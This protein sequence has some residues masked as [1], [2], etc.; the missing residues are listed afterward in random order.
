MFVNNSRV[1]NYF[2]QTTLSRH[3]KCLLHTGRNPQR[4]S[5]DIIQW[6]NSEKFKM[7]KIFLIKNRLH[8]QQQRLLESQ[9]RLEGVVGNNGED[10]T[11]ALTPPESPLS[12]SGNVPNAP[13]VPDVPNAPCQ[14]L[15]LIVQ[16]P[17]NSAGMSLPVHLHSLR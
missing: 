17:G 11:S 1:S 6:L 16:K 2:V 10:G 7:P 15:S 8:M 12:P 4:A 14:P 13:N 9:K 5:G 3:F